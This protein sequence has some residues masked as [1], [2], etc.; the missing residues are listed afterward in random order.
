[1]DIWIKNDRCKIYMKKIPKPILEKHIQLEDIS[2]SCQTHKCRKIECSNSSTS[3]GYKAL[4][5]V[6]KA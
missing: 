5:E 6:K 1:M 4:I 2:D 3:C